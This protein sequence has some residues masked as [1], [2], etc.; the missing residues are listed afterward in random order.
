MHSTHLKEVGS[1]AQCLLLQHLAP[2]G[3][4]RLFQLVARGN[5]LLRCCCGVDLLQLGP[6]HLF[7]GLASSFCSASCP[8]IL[9]FE[10]LP[11]REY[12]NTRCNMAVYRK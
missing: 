7:D 5:M 9:K 10:S 4:H 12:M 6:R 3:M 8:R 2:C 11:L 1:D